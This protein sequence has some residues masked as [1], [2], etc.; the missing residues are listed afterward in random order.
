MEEKLGLVSII[1]AT[2]NAEKTIGVAIDSILAQTYTDWELLVVNDCS[3]DDTTALVSAYSDPRIRLL[4]NDKNSGVS[5]S[6]KKGMEAANG[7]WIAILDSDDKWTQDKLEKQLRFAEKSGGDLIYSGSAFMD[8]NGH[9]INWQ[10]HVPSILTYKELLK[11]NLISNSSVLVKA[12]LYRKYYIVGDGMHEDYAI[13]LQMTKE[14]IIAY[15]IDEP[16]LVYRIAKVSKSSNKIKAAKMNWNTYRYVG[17][18]IIQ[19]AYY[20]FRY[21]INGIMKYKNLR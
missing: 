6:R 12:S 4:E 10:L 13:W 16:L 15:G 5:I 20:E 19:C 9:P 14:G 11:Q 8:D 2:Y 18:N 7:E 17:L 3:K 21:A 1:M